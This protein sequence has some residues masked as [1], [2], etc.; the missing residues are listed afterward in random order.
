MASKK[1]DDTRATADELKSLI[2]RLD[3]EQVTEL[4]GELLQAS[5]QV[6]GPKPS[7]D[8]PEGRRQLRAVTAAERAKKRNTSGLPPGDVHPL[9]AEFDRVLAAR[10]RAPAP[11]PSKPARRGTAGHQLEGVDCDWVRF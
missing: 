8:T 11:E 7:A 2:G 10:N 6:G 5:R 4:L 3:P 9:I 1:A